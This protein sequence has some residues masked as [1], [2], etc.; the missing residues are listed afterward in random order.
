MGR[1]IHIFNDAEAVSLAA[2]ELVVLAA[3]QAIEARGLF[4]LA[5]SGGST[6]KRLYQHLASDAY[7]Q[8]I[9]WQKVHIY[10]GDERSVSPEHPESN[11]RMAR[12]AFLDQLPIPEQQIHRIQGERI[13]LEQ[14]AAEYA[15]LLQTLPTSNGLPQFDLLLLGMGDDGHT[16]SLFPG[17][18]ALT[19]KKKTVVAQTVPQLNTQR[20]TLSYPV[21]NNAHQVMLLV[22]GESKAVR[23]EEVLVSAPKGYY[24]VQGVKP[25]GILN[26]LLDQSAAKKLP[27]ALI[28]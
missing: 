14:A 22:A 23:L 28:E 15:E 13:D 21:I 9:D 8:Q 17:T 3:K 7:R 2:A 20:I 5:L 27:K 12:E 11:Y 16:A 24:P 1:A 26:W 6:P 25:K 10:F 18:V 4:H 19:E